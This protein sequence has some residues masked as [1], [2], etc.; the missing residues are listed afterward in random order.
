M[1]SELTVKMSAWLGHVRSA[2]EQGM[3]L[4]AY[5]AAQGVSAAA[6]YQAKSQ[7]MQVGAWPRSSAPRVR[8][9]SASRSERSA[10]A[11][12][13]VPVQVSDAMSCRLSHVSGWILTCDTLPPTQWLNALL[14]GAALRGAVL[15]DAV[16]P[17]AGHA[18]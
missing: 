3:T 2:S 13:F 17:D 18:A 15:P 12:R 4:A 11:S 8:A 6:L 16:L 1:N 5:A 14:R 9:S 10:P 7:L